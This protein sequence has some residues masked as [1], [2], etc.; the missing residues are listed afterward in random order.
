[1]KSFGQRRFKPR[2][3]TL[4]HRVVP[5]TSPAADLAEGTASSWQVFATD[6]KVGTLSNDS[7]R[8][9]AGS[10]SIRYS[11]SSAS[12]NGVRISSGAQAWN[13]SSYKQLEFWTYTENR[14][15]VGFEGAQPVVTLVTP[16]G[17]FR[18]TPRNQNPLPAN[19]WEKH[20][21]PLTG[22]NYWRRDVIGS[23]SLTNVTRLEIQHDSG[24]GGF[25]ITFDGLR[26]STREVTTPTATGPAAPTGVQNGTITPRVLVY[27]F[28]PV[29]ENKGGARLHDAY[30]LN[31][32]Q[33]LARGLASDLQRSSHGM[34]RP[35]IVETRIVDQHAYFTDGFQYSD[36]SYESAWAS[37]Q[38][39][40]GQFDY[41]RFLRETG[42][43]ARVD[44]G[45]IDEVWVYAAPGS[46]LSSSVMAG[47]SPYKLVGPNQA[48]GQ[49]AFAIMG[50]NIQQGVGDSLVGYG[51]RI[52]ATMAHLYA[53]LSSD[54][55][56]AWRRFTRTDQDAPGLGQVGTVKRPVNATYDYDYNNT[57]TV[58]SMAS[59]WYIYPRLAGNKQLV[60]S[61]TWSPTKVDPKRDYL[62]WWLDHLPDDAGRGPDNRLMN[63]WRY[64]GD[65]E[66][67]KH[68]PEL[69]G[70]DASGFL[71]LTG[72][73]NNATVTGTLQ[74]G[75]SGVVDGVYGRVD[76]YV[77]GVYHSSDT[78]GPFTFQLDTSKLTGGKHTLQ[79]RGYEVQNGTELRS[80]T[81]T[82]NIPI[83]NTAPRL[84]SITAKS[85]NEGSLLTFTATA[86]DTDIG[87]V[88]RYSLG[89][90]APVGAAID[91]VTGVFTWRPDDGAA[92]TTSVLIRVT[93]KGGLSATQVVPLT[94]FNVAP[95][96]TFSS[97]GQLQVGKV[98]TFAFTGATDASAADRAAGYRY[99]FDLNGDGD[100]SDAG[101][102]I[103]TISSFT[104]TFAAAGTYTRRGRVY[105]K[106]G[107]FREYTATVSIATTS[108]GAGRLAD[109]APGS[110]NSSPTELTV[111]GRMLYFVATT[112][113]F[114]EELYR[115]DGT[116]A[117][118][119]LVKDITPGKGGSLPRN[120]TNVNGVLYFTAQDAN[121]GV[122][123]WRSDGTAAGTRMVRDINPGVT[124]SWP[125]NL[126]NVGGILYFTATTPTNGVE[127]WRS[128]G[129]TAGT[130]L[131]RDLM[132]GTASGSPSQLTA[133]G[134]TLYF[135]AQAPGI[136]AELFRTNGTSSST[137]MVRDI[138]PGTMPSFI[139]GLVNAGGTL[140][141]S[142]YTSALGQELWKSN[143]TST[144]TVL[145]RDIVPGSGSSSP[146]QM[147]RALNRVFFIANNNA[148][149]TELWVTDGS[150]SGTRL[151]S[152]INPG[153]ASSE[154]T[155]LIEFNGAVYFS[156]NTQAQG[157]ELWRSDGTAAGTRLVRDLQSG[158][159]SSSPSSFLVSGGALWFVA[160]T[161]SGGQQ[162]WRTDGSTSGTVSLS[163]L[164]P[165]VRPSWASTP[166]DVAGT[167]FFVA[168]DSAGGYEVWTTRRTG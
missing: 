150:S 55:N 109:L 93:D 67:F 8:V 114:G 112:A 60:S 63:W 110:A 4:E 111:V 156:A 136:G 69:H 90:G 28:D 104:R 46:G 65:V 31:D 68:R 20:H 134:T 123:L 1:M 16:T 152:D 58:Q 62:N 121:N 9:V 120:L 92:Q 147:V 11:T 6:G 146:S 89:S 70:S 53:A 47:A 78:L 95:T 96:A 42:L 103:G 106:D 126:T 131:V 19:A 100:F 43:S 34:Y 163:S 44:R 50:M 57:R 105:D 128:D 158:T 51:F 162:L 5:T 119:V 84:N 88:L 143:G 116:T 161:S 77:N 49:R 101:E 40:V 138:N 85:V 79:V 129:T 151:V 66:A 142:A 130:Y 132:P 99:S 14:T 113:T 21:I 167:I 127:L 25:A 82:I 81:W 108:S 15:S 118:T 59:D 115:S 145:V 33:T 144:G 56:N 72:V 64:V 3:E 83:R 13:V 102:A 32:P 38:M 37:K 149:G 154:P 52:E 75:A 48:A 137:V 30:R 23:P 74:L 2:L 117:G 124:S 27:V 148:T 97:S 35:Q 45:E 159:A 98:I 139:S 26:F 10:Q 107:A 122:E 168:Y 155:S 153:L 125:S 166:V 141:F 17:G 54:T 36:S 157:V 29:M 24:A 76:L 133:M 41:A 86:S 71:N 160:W 18:F 91:P 164:Y 73:Q 22:D 39:H 165:T 80:A 135:V 140:Y 12:T 7:T 87:D 94:V 61:S